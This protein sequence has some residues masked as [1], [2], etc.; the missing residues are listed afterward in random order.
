MQEVEMPCADAPLK[1]LGH[2]QS[3]SRTDKPKPDAASESDER[4][5]DERLREYGELI[6]RKR[7]RMRRFFPGRSWFLP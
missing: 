7:P 4:A 3:V 1:D 6:A 5:R 2:Q